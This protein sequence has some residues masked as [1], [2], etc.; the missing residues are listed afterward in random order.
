MEGIGES[1]HQYRAVNRRGW[2]EL[3]QRGCSYST[4][5]TAA[6]LANAHSALCPPGW[7]DWAAV[8]TVLCLASGGGQQGPLAAALGK[9]VTVA[10]LSPEQ[11]ALDRSTA[12]AHGLELE[13]IELDMQDLSVLHGRGFD[14]VIQ[15]VSC[16]YVPDVRQVYREVAR[17]LAPG[18]LYLVNQWNPTL[19]QMPEHG[20]WD[21]AA[22]RLVVPQTQRDPVP[23]TVWTIHGTAHAITTWQ[24]IH[25][26]GDLLGGL[27]DAGF[28][29]LRFVEA[30]EPD[31]GASPG[32]MNHLAAFAP[33]LFQILARAPA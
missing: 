24:Y 31:L 26:L 17:V 2:A 7:I 10:D 30:G 13:T 9:R 14:V 11:L 8:R 32:S 16:C 1:Q 3:V 29:L 27:L 33:P 5:V 23:Q 4:P 25:P 15:P 28:S 22:Y 21:G 6:A 20:D 18:G 12:A 19:I